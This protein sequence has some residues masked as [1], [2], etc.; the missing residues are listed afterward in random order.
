M[1]K[2]T[3]ILFAI[4]LTTI[5]S[6]TG[7]A[8]KNELTTLRIGASPIPHT[9]ILEHVKPLLAEEGFNQI[10]RASCRERF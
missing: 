2:T 10:G 3:K 5:I 1:M 7:C 9:L 8:K 6:T 4:G